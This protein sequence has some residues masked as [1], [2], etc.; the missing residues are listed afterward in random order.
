MHFKFDSYFVH[1]PTVA[2]LTIQI[3]NNLHHFTKIDKDVSNFQLPIYYYWHWHKRIPFQDARRKIR[4]ETFK[5]R[6]NRQLKDLFYQD[7]QRYDYII[8]LLGITHEVPKLGVIVYKTT[9]KDEIKRLTTE[10]CDKI[11]DERLTEYHKELKSKQDTLKEDFEKI[12]Q[13]IK[14]EEKYLGTQNPSPASQS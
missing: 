4:Q 12:E 1:F 9:R 6:R 3:R 13:L 11:K 5:S 7:R 2:R 10:Y 8:K 14:E